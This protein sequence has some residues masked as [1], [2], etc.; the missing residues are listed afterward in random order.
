GIEEIKLSVAVEYTLTG[1]GFEVAVPDDSIREAGAVRLTKLEVLPFFHAVHERLDEGAVFLP[2]GSGA[3]MTVKGRHPQYFNGYSE[4]VYGPDH[5][6]DEELGTVLA[7]GF[8][9]GDA[10]K[11]KIAL[12]V[13]G[14]YQGGT[15]FLAIIT[16]GEETA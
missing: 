8:I 15:G 16:E 9:V 1:D 11:E 12:P 7:D 3:L 10:P 14:I 13:F 2:A 4:P 5:A 6:F